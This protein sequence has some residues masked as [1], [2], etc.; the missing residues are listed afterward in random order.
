MNASGPFDF[1]DAAALVKA[2]RRD[3]HVTLKQANYDYERVQYN[4]VV[5]AGMKMLNTL[6]GVPATERGGAALLCEGLSILLRALDPVVPHTAWVLWQDLGYAAKQGDLIDA[7]WPEVDA[8]ALVQ[9][10]VELMLQV[11]GKLRGKLSVPAA[12]AEAAID[13][14]AR[15][16][17]EVVKYADGKPVKKVIIVPGRLVNVVV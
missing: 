3:L 8:A 11:N 1:G 15:A 2:A 5:S 13:A 12:A 7:P 16:H 6:E 14:A 9:E 4:T 10:E 17:A